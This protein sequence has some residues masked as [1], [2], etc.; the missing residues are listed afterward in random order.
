MPKVKLRARVILFQVI[1]LVEL[2]PGNLSRRTIIFKAILLQWEWR[3]SVYY[4]RIL[5]LRTRLVIYY[6]RVA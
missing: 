6:F 4:I 2:Y 3:L 5:Y 1:E